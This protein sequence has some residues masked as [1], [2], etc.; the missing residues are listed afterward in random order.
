ME[1][2]SY[3][4]AGPDP[5]MSEFYESIEAAQEM[6]SASTLFLAQSF[7]AYTQRVIVNSLDH[8]SYKHILEFMFE[9]SG[10][11]LSEEWSVPMGFN[12]AFCMFLHSH[13]TT[14]MALSSTGNR[15]YD[16]SYSNEACPCL[17]IR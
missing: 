9:A 8:P 1:S 15:I 13:A 5:S 10:I 6:L 3:M 17:L 4:S 7:I 16:R 14:Q 2:S 12:S 11:Y